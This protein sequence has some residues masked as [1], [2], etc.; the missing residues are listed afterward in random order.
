MRQLDDT[1]LVLLSSGRWDGDLAVGSVC[2]PGQAT[3]EHEWG[4]ELEGAPRR[5][6][7]DGR[8]TPTVGPSWL[9]PG[10][11]TF[12]PTFPS[13]RTPGVWCGELGAG[14]EALFLSEYGVGSLFDAVTALAEA[15]CHLGRAGAA[16]TPGGEPPDVAYVRAMAERFTSDWERF[17]MDELYCFPED[18]LRGRASY[19]SRSTGPP[20]ST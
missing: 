9:A 20:P 11:S 2:N 12:T 15:S 18:A 7:W 3:W 1:R 13:R 6:T 10:T 4:S 8:T 14:Y 5:W 16:T 17:G 19:T